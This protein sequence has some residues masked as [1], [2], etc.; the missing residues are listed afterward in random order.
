VTPEGF[1][2]VVDVVVAAEVV[3]VVAADVDVV[4]AADVDVVVGAEVVVDVAGAPLAAEVV[5]PPPEF[6]LP[7]LPQAANRTTITPL[8]V[9]K[10]RHL[11][12]EGYHRQIGLLLGIS[13]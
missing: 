8:E 7:L 5:V 13:P 12:C 6:P 2:A 9:S 1:G 3:V 11:T 10:R 4:V